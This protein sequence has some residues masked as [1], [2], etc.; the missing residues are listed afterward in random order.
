MT[1]AAA[2][3]QHSSHPLFPAASYQSTAMAGVFLLIEHQPPTS[4]ES[5][6]IIQCK[7]RITLYTYI[8]Q[9][10]QH[11]K[12]ARR[13]THEQDDYMNQPQQKQGLLDRTSCI[14]TVLLFSLEQ[15]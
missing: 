8:A 13:R 10:R 12:D 15:T 14:S 9:Q 2:K 6:H 3:H 4:N 5:P 1:I 11:K 7:K